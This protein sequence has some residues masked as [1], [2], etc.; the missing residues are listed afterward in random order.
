MIKRERWAQQCAV[1]CS[2]QISKYDTLNAGETQ[3]WI[4]SETWKH[5]LGETEGMRR[6]NFISTNCSLCWCLGHH[7]TLYIFRCEA[8]KNK[9]GRAAELLVV[10]AENMAA[11]L[12][13]HL[14]FCFL[15]PKRSH[16]AVV[17]EN[18]PHPTP[19]HMI[20]NW[21]TPKSNQSLLSH[22]NLLT[23]VALPVFLVSLQ[24][25]ALP[26]GP[27]LP[28]WPWRWFYSYTNFTISK[29]ACAPSK[30]H[31]RVTGYMRFENSFTSL[32]Q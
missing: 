14:T 1:G 15:S 2:L 32:M 18:S 16:S 23:L 28:K 8:A 11:F 3:G 22:I 19:P 29:L 10:S 25:P 26:L 17:L 21:A 24:E 6:P 4:L 13:K 20:L 31:L 9:C 27:F 30:Q 5:K 12:D 7:L